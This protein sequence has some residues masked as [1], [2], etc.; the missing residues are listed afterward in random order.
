V[1]RR[2]SVVARKWIAAFAKQTNP[3]VDALF[4]ADAYFSLMED[5]A[6]NIDCLNCISQVFLDDKNKPGPVYF[7]CRY[8]PAAQINDPSFESRSS[9]SL[10]AVHAVLRKDGSLGLM[11]INKPRR[12]DATVQGQISGAHWRRAERALILGPRTSPTVI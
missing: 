5:G 9:Q 11:L 8:S 7:A 12:N 10:L 4:A 1:Y 6:A 3:H 2:F